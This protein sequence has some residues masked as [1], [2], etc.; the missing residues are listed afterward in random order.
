M[1]HLYREMGIV[2]LVDGVQSLFQRGTGQQQ[3]KQRKKLNKV[4]LT[5]SLAT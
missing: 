5:T 4:I 2:C 1:K 3:Q